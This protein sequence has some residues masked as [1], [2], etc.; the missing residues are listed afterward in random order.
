M[1]DRHEVH[2]RRAAAQD[3]WTDALREHVKTC[4]DCAAAA[5]ATP[6]MKRLAAIDDRA[7]ALP[8]PAV[9]WLKAQIFRGTALA[10]RATRPLNVAQIVAYLVVAAGW[11]SVLTWKWADLQRWILGFTPAGMVQSVSAN[12]L[13]LTFMLA[14]V[15]L[16]SMTVMLA[17]HT[18]LAED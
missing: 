2:V 3:Q 13:S 16:A 5:A 4:A 11:A 10:E 6:F 15:V 12:P 9:L 1:S 17:L 8:D 18:I 14:I 7:R